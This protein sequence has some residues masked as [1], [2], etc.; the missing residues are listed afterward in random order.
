MF[1]LKRY[2][3]LSPEMSKY[4]RESTNKSI[5]NYKINPYSLVLF[6]KNDPPKFFALLPFVSFIS[7]LAGYKFCKLTK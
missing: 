3:M 2:P 6:E 1:S 5:E 4:I 7:F